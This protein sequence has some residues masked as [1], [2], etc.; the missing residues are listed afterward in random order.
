MRRAEDRPGTEVE[1]VRLKFTICLFALT[2][3]I[4]MA[5]PHDS[6]YGHSIHGV[7]DF[8]LHVVREAS[9]PVAHQNRTR[10]PANAN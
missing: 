6:G 4:A 3:D 1:E 10:C 9:S 7:C 8:C 5:T 2:N